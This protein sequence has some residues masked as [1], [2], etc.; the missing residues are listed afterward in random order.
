MR[1]LGLL[2]ALGAAA[3]LAGCGP[4]L[5]VHPLYTEKDLVSDMPLEGKWTE[6]EDKEVWNVRKLGASYEAEA[7]GSSNPEKVEFYVVRLGELRFLDITTAAPPSLAVPGH[8][9]TKVWMEGEELR[10]QVLDSDWLKQKIRETGFPSVELADQQLILTAPTRELQ[11]FVLLY[12]A[13]PKAY[14]SEVGKFRRVRSA[15]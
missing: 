4:T 15:P 13:E 1:H 7:P 10:L 2:V 6:T 14:A 8:M 5:A 11:K 12:A 9:F 3:L